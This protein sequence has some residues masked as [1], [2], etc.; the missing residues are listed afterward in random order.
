MSVDSDVAAT[1][2][3]EDSSRPLTVA[4]IAVL[5]TA[6]VP[7]VSG[8]FWLYLYAL[9]TEYYSTFG[10][11][12]EQIGLTQSVILARAGGRALLLV[13]L[14]AG[15]YFFAGACASAIL[16]AGARSAWVRDA[17]SSPTVISGFLSQRPQGARAPL[18][19]VYGC[20]LLLFVGA[21]VA[22][23]SSSRVA[24]TWLTN[25]LALILVA[26]VFTAAA[27]FFLDMWD[28]AGK[29]RA[30]VQHV[31]VPL[32]ALMILL[33]ALGAYS[34]VGAARGAAQDLVSISTE[35]PGLAGPLSGLE[36]AVVGVLAATDVSEVEVRPIGEDVAGLC[37]SDAEVGYLRLGWTPDVLTIVEVGARRGSPQEFRGGTFSAI[38]VP[39]G[40]YSVRTI[41]GAG[42]LGDGP[43]F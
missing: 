43:C 41:D 15:P 37:S 13:V 11:T 7:F 1:T 12:L 6:S 19:Y 24:G 34:S 39:A 4:R 26:M 27:L 10:V 21:F 31:R 23:M 42:P 35:K 8:L 38:T 3:E 36:T 2:R 29:F 32:V 16:D 33:L 40:A 30:L 9:Y 5:L 14:V 17:F 18:W 25:L 22:V 28:R 20:C